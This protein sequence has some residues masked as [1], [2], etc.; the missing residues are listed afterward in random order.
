[1]N[2]VRVSY[3]DVLQQEWLHD[4][5]DNV[6][7]GL[8]DEDL[9][10]DFDAF[11]GQIS[12]PERQDN[13]YCILAMTGTIPVGG[14]TAEY[15]PGSN[16]CVIEF[17]Q[18]QQSFQSA[19]EELLYRMVELLHQIHRKAKHVFIEL[20]HNARN[21]GDGFFAKWCRRLDLKYTT[22][23]IKED[24]EPGMGLCLC[25]VD[26]LIGEVPA[27]E[28]CSFINEYFQTSFSGADIRPY[29]PR[30]SGKIKVY[31]L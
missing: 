27:E 10:P 4:F 16:C 17:L 18:A 11:F 25:V 24:G 1:M 9:I 31:Q 13:W 3:T 21:I 2:F 29:L 28:V 15:M 20:V 7:T 22:P 30:V 26:E 8:Y 23:P 19:Q 12:D 14:I 6:L 5:Y